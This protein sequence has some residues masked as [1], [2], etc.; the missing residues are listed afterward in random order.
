M[1][2]YTSKLT[3]IKINMWYKTWFLFKEMAQIVIF[4][5][6]KVKQN[7]FLWFGHFTLSFVS[8]SWYN[9]FVSVN[10]LLGVS[11]PWKAK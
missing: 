9:N 5:N 10:S 3:R 2:H 11:L 1:A 8:V 7:H 6:C 4:K